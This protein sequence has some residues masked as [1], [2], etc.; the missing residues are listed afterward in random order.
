MTKADR[1]RSGYLSSTQ[2]EAM[3]DEIEFTPEGVDRFFRE[4]SNKSDVKL[5][6]FRALFFLRGSKVCVSRL[7]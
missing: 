6:R 2:A 7:I 4:L 3:L 5:M 1:D